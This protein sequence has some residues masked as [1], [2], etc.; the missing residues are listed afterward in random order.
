M[1][2]LTKVARGYGNLELREMAIPTI[3][4]DEV[5]VEIKAA[6]ICGSD[7]Q[8]FKQGD[9]LAIPVV[10]GHEF[11]G[12]IVQIGDQVQGWT[13]GER[14]VSETHAYTCQ[15][16]YLCKTGDYH[17]CKERKGFGYSV[18]GAFA[19]YIAVPARMLHRIS[20]DMSYEEATVLQPA[21]DVINAVIKNTRIEP[22][23]AV[24]VIG[25]GPMGLLATQVA[26]VAGARFVIVVGLAH[27]TERL[28]LA[29]KLGADVTIN[30]TDED[31]I[32]R[33]GALTEGRGAEVVLETSG[34]EKALL[35]GLDLL[36]A[37]GQLTI[38][39]V[40]IKPLQINIRALQ[41]K[42]QCIKGSTKSAWL[43]Y[44]RAIHL[45]K[46]GRLQLKELISHVLPL[47]QWEEGFDIAV[48][49][50]GCKVV[51]NLTM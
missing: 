27:H 18:D 51:F 13:E 33:V 19:E 30:A 28:K 9:G 6:G 48:S 42:D 35:Q 24:V 17:L 47:A 11:S 36:A 4:G 15:K 45:T 40:P 39:G 8:H 20:E 44:E 23:A 2:A 1:K 12:D 7:L 46:T 10:L 32:A 41:L 31:T 5:L 16:C 3:K 14:I 22:G 26:R 21:A 38:I 37:N 25:P 34:T 29:E 43:D 49:K 50:K